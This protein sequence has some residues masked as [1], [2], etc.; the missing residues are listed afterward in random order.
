MTPIRIIFLVKSYGEKVLTC[1]LSPLIK[2][3]P[4][5]DHRDI[6]CLNFDLER[7]DLKV[8]YRKLDLAVLECEIRDLVFLKIAELCALCFKS[9]A[10]LGSALAA[11]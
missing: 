7:Y 8:G 1:R 3:I 9:E 5:N 6:F 2:N 4:M 11:E 10:Q